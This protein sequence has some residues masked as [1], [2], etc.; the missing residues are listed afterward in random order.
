MF[1]RRS[2]RKIKV[3]KVTPLPQPETPKGL[4]EQMFRLSERHQ[5]RP[6]SIHLT[7]PFDLSSNLN[8]DM[9]FANSSALATF[10]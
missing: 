2:N 10:F 9:V 6:H 8:I 1:K 4:K 5:V 7:R 3:N